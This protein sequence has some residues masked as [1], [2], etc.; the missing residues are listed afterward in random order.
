MLSHTMNFRKS[1]LISSNP[2]IS[3]LQNVSKREIKTQ[4]HRFRALSNKKNCTVCQVACFRYRQ[5]L[6]AELPMLC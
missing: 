2:P 6:S 1:D 4:L 3:R 5:A